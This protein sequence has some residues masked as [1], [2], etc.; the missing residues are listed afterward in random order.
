MVPLAVTEGPAIALWAVILW[1]YVHILRIGVHTR[2]RVRNNTSALKN[3][4]I[5]N[6]FGSVR[7]RAR[8]RVYG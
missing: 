8:V 5:S 7:V 2:C 3:E 1:I 6:R 4:A